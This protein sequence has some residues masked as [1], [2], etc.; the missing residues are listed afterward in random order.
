ME[1][2]DSALEQWLEKPMDDADRMVVAIHDAELL[3]VEY[4]R[5]YEPASFQ[6]LVDFLS[7]EGSPIES[8]VLPVLIG[9]IANLQ[10]AGK[11]CE[12]IDEDLDDEMDY[13]WMLSKESA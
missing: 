2:N 1:T 4:L 5:K 8:P 9:A 7:A 3:V 11:I 13:S 6:E 10:N 12:Y